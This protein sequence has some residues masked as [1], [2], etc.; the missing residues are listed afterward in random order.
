[1]A[2]R[3]YVGKQGL[4]DFFAKAGV[5]SGGAGICG[6]EEVGGVGICQVNIGVNLVVL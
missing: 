5:E 2:K 3:W 6:S 4:L 1:M